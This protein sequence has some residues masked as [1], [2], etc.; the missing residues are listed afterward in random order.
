[1]SAFHRTT[2]NVHTYP[3][4]KF[5]IFDRVTVGAPG[6]DGDGDTSTDTNSRGRT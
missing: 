1:M 2:P 5:C 4:L 3:T 6:N